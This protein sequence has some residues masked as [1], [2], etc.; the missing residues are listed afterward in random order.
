MTDEQALADRIVAL[1]VG[2]YTGTDGPQGKGLDI[3]GALFERFPEEFIRDGRVVLALM[4]KCVNMDTQPN[5]EAWIDPSDKQRYKCVT[6]D[7]GPHPFSETQNE[8]LAIAITT[9]CVEALEQSD[10]A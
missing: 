3:P 6:H 7:Y 2:R 5:V 10:G 9:A 4:E 1:G 8:S